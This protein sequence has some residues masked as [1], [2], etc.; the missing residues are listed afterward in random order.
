MKV[1][2]DTLPALGN[3]VVPALSRTDSTIACSVELLRGAGEGLTYTWHSSLMDTT[4][5]GTGA[6]GS[7]G[8]NVTYTIG[9]RDTITVVAANAYGSD[10]MVRTVQVMDC[11][12]V[13]ALPWRE[14]FDDGLTCWYLTQNATYHRWERSYRYSAPYYIN[15]YYA[16]SQCN[17]SESLTTPADA[18]MV[19]RAITLPADTALAV[20]L[21]W[22]VAISSGNNLTNNYRV[23]VSTAA[24]CTDTTLFEE[25]YHDTLPLPNQ[26]GF[27]QRSVSLAAYAG[28]TIFIAFRN[29]PLVRR[30]TALMI[31]KVEVRE[32]AKPSLLLAH[33]HLHRHPPGG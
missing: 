22:E 10:T 24:D 29:Q 31:D 21:F 8:F 18:W 14:D 11:R 19:S 32:T 16:F 2:Y 30:A 4:W 5:V 12:P 9:G 3:M 15:D 23:M 17:F 33:R 28:Q 7:H 6:N 1:D 26:T 25:L 27:A 13:T 20:H